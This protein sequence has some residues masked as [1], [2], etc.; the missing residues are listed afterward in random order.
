MRYL[1][2]WLVALALGAPAVPAPSA[3]APADRGASTSYVF[4]PGDIVDVTVSS[5]MG[6]DRTITIQPDGRIQFP[7]VGEIVAAGLTAAQLAA[8]IQE[9]LNAGLVDP[10][11]TVSLKELNKGLLRRVSVLGAVKT[12]G[13]FELKE[14][15]TLAELLA[16]AG[17]PTP[18][19][20]LHRVTVTRADGSKKVVADL[21]GAA[22]TGEVSN[23]LAL[24]P[25]DLIWVP[26]GTSP[27]VLVLGE[28]VKPGSYEL[29]GEMRVLNALSLAGGPTTKADLRHVTLTHAGQSSKEVIDLD[30]LLTRG[31]QQN[32]TANVV[33]RPGDALVIPESERKFYVF[34][35]VN[36]ADAYPLKPAD[37]LLDAITTAGGSTHEA[38]LAQV[39][40]IRKD[41]KGQLVP[42]RID[43]KRML[44][45]GDM[46]RNE[47]LREGD[48][49]FVPNRKQRHPITDILGFLNPVSSLLYVLGR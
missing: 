14:Q 30:D 1:A 48:V 22:R 2:L 46:V 43:L 34:G 11:V 17:G 7:E 44:K 35:E 36:K 18:V 29:Q 4:V 15:S 39:M 33:L 40:L 49:I 24:E 38:D 42:R 12:Q 26:E 10:R 41:E 27:T 47:A 20:D 32:L 37:H 19:A 23:N 3:A 8:R 28:V 9:G 13:V 21:S 45:N 25:G 5:H 16:T 6:Y 31:Q